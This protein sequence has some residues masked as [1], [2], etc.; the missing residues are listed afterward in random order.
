MEK[1]SDNLAAQEAA[2]SD[3]SPWRE[4]KCEK[5]GSLIQWRWTGLR[6]VAA[7]GD[8]NAAGKEYKPVPAELLASLLAEAM[9][10]YGRNSTIGSGVPEWYEKAAL[11]G[12]A[13][14]T[15]R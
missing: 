3:T 10:W 11:L 2:V 12:T 4:G 15:S 14:S 8:E 9:R 7:T 1:N 6:T 13:R 5:C